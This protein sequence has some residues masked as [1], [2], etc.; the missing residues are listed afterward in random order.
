M[1]YRDIALSCCGAGY[2]AQDSTL[3]VDL[4]G[5]RELPRCYFIADGRE[6]P[7]GMKKFETGSARHPKALHLQPFW[8]GAQRSCDALG[9][10]IYRAKDLTAAE[11]TR[12]KAILCFAVPT[13]SG[14][15]ARH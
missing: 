5:G 14:S 6:D 1:L 15:M 7:Y 8:A 3:V 12:C 10:A 13:P 2:G 4:P 9:L 11:V